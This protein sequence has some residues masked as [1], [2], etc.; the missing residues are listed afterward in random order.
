MTPCEVKFGGRIGDRKMF[1]ELVIEGVSVDEA[2]THA[3]SARVIEIAQ[4]LVAEGMAL[5]PAKLAPFSD[6]IAARI[7]AAIPGA[8]CRVTQLVAS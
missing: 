1:G 8:T 6:A 7:A 4:Q 3:I 2:T 5:H